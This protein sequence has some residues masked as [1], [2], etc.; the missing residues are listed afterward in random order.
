MFITDFFSPYKNPQSKTSEQHNRVVKGCRINTVIE[1]NHFAQKLTE[2]TIISKGDISK[3]VELHLNYYYPNELLRLFEEAH[4]KTL[5]VHGD[6]KLGSLSL[7]S[8]V[9]VFLL[10]RQK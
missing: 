10:Q 3:L 9:M 8:D 6:F 5:K 1:Y 2:H 4:F 7:D